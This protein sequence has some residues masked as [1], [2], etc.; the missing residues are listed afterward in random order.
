MVTQG[1]S[2]GSVGGETAAG[3]TSFHWDGF[4]FLAGRRC[5]KLIAA[6]LFIEDPNKLKWEETTCFYPDLSF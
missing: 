6:R 1:L 4:F 5:R 3:K 2:P